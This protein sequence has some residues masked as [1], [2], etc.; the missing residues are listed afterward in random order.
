M[1]RFTAWNSDPGG[2]P[3]WDGDGNVG[4]LDLFVLFANWGPCP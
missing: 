3:D 4:I 1:S 2:P